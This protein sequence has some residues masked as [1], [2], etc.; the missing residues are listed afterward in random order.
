MAWRPGSRAAAVALEEP[1]EDVPAHLHEPLWAWLEMHIGNKPNALRAA[2]AR[3]RLVIPDPGN[4]MSWSLRGFRE[5]CDQ[6]PTLMLDAVEFLLPSV[7]R[8]DGPQAAQELQR[9]LL[10]CHSLYRVRDDGAGLEECIDPA[11]RDRMREVVTAAVGSPG[12]HLTA[13]WNCAYGRTL[14]PVKAYS[15]AIKAVEAAAA[16]IVSPT[17]AKATLGTMIRD[18]KAKPSKWTFAISAQGDDGVLAVL[19]MM[20]ALWDGQTSR[21]GGNAPTQPETPESA[22]AAVHLAATL[23]QFFIGGG[24]TMR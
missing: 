24:V 11:V 8:L 6:R 20:A 3:L 2:A 12:E 5:H 9:L 23:V 18:V 1:F 17:N 21:H 15:E 19:R 4:M 16:P 7:V 13:A 10:V 22:R 14:D